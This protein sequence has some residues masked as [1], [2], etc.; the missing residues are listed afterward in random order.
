MATERRDVRAAR[1]RA[2]E[3]EARARDEVATVLASGG[4]DLQ[5]HLRSVRDD[6]RLHTVRR[7]TPLLP[8][9]E[10][11]E[12]AELRLAKQ[13]LEAIADNVPDVIYHYQLRPEQG[14]EY[15]SP[16]SMRLLGYEPAEFYANPR[17]WQRF[18]HPDDLERMV[19]EVRANPAIPVQ[20]LRLVR[21]DGV[22]IHC[23]VS[24]SLIRD[25]WGRVAG[26]V[27]VI[28]DETER[29]RTR[30]ELEES[31]EQVQKLDAERFRLLRKLVAAHENERRRIAAAIHDDSI[32]AVAALAIRVSAM[33]MKTTDERLKASLGDI[34]A[35]VS[36]A[37]SRLRGLMF[38]LHP[39]TLDRGGLAAT[40]EAHVGRFT[41]EGEPAYVLYNQ[42]RSEPSRE[43]A[44]ALYRVIQEAITNARKHA[45]AGRILVELKEED[46]DFMARVKD[47]GYGFEVKEIESPAGHLGLS[48]MREQAEMVGGRISIE[49][50]RSKGTTVEARIPAERAPGSG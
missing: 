35:S 3:F 4:Q 25:R 12:S 45:R 11:L 21:K 9:A 1:S 36:E 38:E 13:R 28:R 27:G 26:V 6:E 5:V 18:I 22:T 15:V 30:H 20:R 39:T 46:G 14:Y 48:T 10:E 41:D 34:E 19:S 17:L 2:R 37:V 24:N 44:L 50:S 49:S 31:A 29:I 42:L 47:D 40:V 8:P 16:A 33:R 23:Q 7:P 43:V 32:Q